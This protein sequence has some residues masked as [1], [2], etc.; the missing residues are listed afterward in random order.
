MK[1]LIIAALALWISSCDVFTPE[2]VTLKSGTYV[3]R[4]IFMSRPAGTRECDEKTIV[5]HE[6]NLV[7]DTDG[8]VTGT[9]TI[10]K[11]LFSDRKLWE[12]QFDSLEISAVFEGNEI[13]GSTWDGEHVF[14]F[15]WE[16]DGSGTRII[17]DDEAFAEE[18]S[19]DLIAGNNLGQTALILELR[20]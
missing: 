8:R 14:D 13:S 7:V 18:K 20:E 11:E 17:V 9:Q 3:G 5:D 2:Q 16:V 10:I 19:I 1:N 15:E 4:Q 12:A 6:V